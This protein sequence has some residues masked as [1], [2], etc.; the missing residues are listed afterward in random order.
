[1]DRAFKHPI[2]RL[3]YDFVEPN[4]LPAD[5]N[6]Y[7]LRNEQL[8]DIS[9]FRSLTASE[10]EILVKNDN[11]AG[12]WTDILVSDAFDPHLVKDCH[13]HGLIRIGALQPF[14]L[15]HH[16]LKLPVGLYNS[17]I[18][19]CDIGDNVVIKNV[20]YLAHYQ[21]SDEVILFNINEMQTT[22]HAKFGNGILKEGEDEGTRIWLEI[23]NENGGRKVLPFEGMLPA[24]AWL[25]SKFRDNQPLMNRLLEMTEL[26]FDDRRGYYGIVGERTIIKNTRIVKDVKVGAYAY[27]KGGNKL[28][29]LTILSDRT[30]PSQI[31]EGVEMVNGIMGYGSKAFYGVK[32]VRFV[33]GENTSLKYGARLL[34][35]YL[36]D[37][38]TISC[39]EVL[40]SLIFPGHEQH[41]NNSF[42]IASTLLGQSNIAAAASIGSN[43]NSRAADGEMIAGRGF[44]PGLGTSL[45]FNSKFA[46]F[47][48]IARGSYASELNIPLP[49]ALVS[50]NK[51]EDC[52][53]VMPAYWWMYNM[54]ALARGTWK[55]R[56]RDRRRHKVQGL[57]FDYLAPDT[58]SE[59]LAGLELLETW[60]GEAYNRAHSNDKHDAKTLAQLGKDLLEKD[61]QTVR[62]LHV[63]GT[64][65]EN[66]KREVLILKAVEAYQ[67]YFEMVH[68]YCLKTLFDFADLNEIVGWELLQKRLSGG[69]IEPWSNVGGQLM[70]SSELD[71][72]IEELENGSIQKWEQLHARYQTIHNQYDDHNASFA[73]AT[74]LKLYNISEH[75]VSK[76]EWWTW[77]DKATNISHALAQRT[78]QSR[79]KDYVNLFRQNT[80]E[81]QQEMDAVLGNLD[82]NAFIKQMQEEAKAFELRA[83]K[84]K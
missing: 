78:M 8:G 5:A 60:T 7:H 23:C 20:D 4:L 73:F 55:Y 25:W 30:A 14:Y 41:H 33:M 51:H 12:N 74:L 47:C 21:I 52:L 19:S 59:I 37:N 57:V 44:W 63:L 76:K 83:N 66:S 61:P 82:D 67:A 72:L 43:H 2:N 10:I 84:M 70:P 49:F 50:N 27:L 38:S 34:N 18:V 53:Q 39:C 32:A 54:Y 17:T 62:S 77:I 15:E 40:N 24:D 64:Q 31:G 29:N 6:E 16:D 28:K 75:D 79:K 9:P 80:Y 36:G 3:G 46:S 45:T 69:K 81:H 48:L 56:H 22:S 65:M 58:I 26:A 71:K 42:L 1:M 11:Q 35:S 13:F 68:Y